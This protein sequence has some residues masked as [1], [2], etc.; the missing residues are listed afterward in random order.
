VEARHVEE[1]RY[2]VGYITRILHV[3]YT[4]NTR[5]LQVRSGHEV[6]IATYGRTVIRVALTRGY[7]QG[8]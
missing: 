2:L 1:V 6:V 7:K 4:Y 3:Y 8:S 5:M